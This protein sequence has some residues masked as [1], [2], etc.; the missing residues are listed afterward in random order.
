MNP[1]PRHVR[2]LLPAI[3]ILAGLSTAPLA[4]DAAVIYKRELPDGTVV[5]SD[6]PHPDAQEFRPAAP[7]LIGPFAAPEPA[8]GATGGPAQ[9][10][11]V[12]DSY[13]A[14]AITAPA[15]DEVIWNDDRRMA[16][17][18]AAEPGLRRGHRITILLDG[19]RIAQTSAAGTI[20][21]DN[22]HRGTHRLEA[23][24]EDAAGRALVRS[25]AITFHMRQH[26]ILNPQ[27]P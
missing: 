8:R 18:V 26:S 3:A 21:L 9:A 17:T 27:R 20:H 13:D 16:V 25:G 12:P 15:P 1:L 11:A 19:E 14:L 22:V 7:Q 6:Q 10:R 4:A 2:R 23:V 24:V 5:Y